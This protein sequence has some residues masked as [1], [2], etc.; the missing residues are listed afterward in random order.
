MADTA[1]T[2]SLRYE[3]IHP[4]SGRPDRPGARKRIG[5]ALAG[6]VVVAGKAKSLLL[7]LPKLKLLASLAPPSYRSAPTR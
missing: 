5:A 2:E 7:L 3:P 1:A 4:G 6:L